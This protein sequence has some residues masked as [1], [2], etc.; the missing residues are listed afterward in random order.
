MPEYQEKKIQKASLGVVVL[1]RQSIDM[2]NA[3][4]ARDDLGNGDPLEMYIDMMDSLFPVALSQDS[5]L[6]HVQWV[7][8]AGQPNSSRLH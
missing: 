1:G 6:S 8:Y 7:K 4:D 5:L 2:E 3:D